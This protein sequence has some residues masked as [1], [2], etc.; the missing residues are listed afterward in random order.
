MQRGGRGVGYKVLLEPQRRA[1]GEE[2]WRCASVTH[3]AGP[4]PQQWS[5]R[6]LA[7]PIRGPW[8]V[9]VGEAKT[10]EEEGPT[11]GAKG[12]SNPQGT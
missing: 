10:G 11:R 12:G 9:G 1:S 2:W 6:P 8:C 4:A 3:T 7:A 5:L